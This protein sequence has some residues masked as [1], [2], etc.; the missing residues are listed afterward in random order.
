MSLFRFSFI[1]M[2]IGLKPL[3]FTVPVMGLKP[4]YSPLCRAT[5]LLRSRC[6]AALCSLMA[7]LCFLTSSCLML[8]YCLLLKPLWN[9]LVS[10]PLMSSGCSCADC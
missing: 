5:S 4:L 3:W 9:L 1:V 6:A 7:S 8:P 10:T 2:V